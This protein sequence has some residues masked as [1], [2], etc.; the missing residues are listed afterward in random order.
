M[1]TQ[2]KIFSW[3]GVLGVALV[4]AAAVLALRECGVEAGSWEACAVDAPMERAH[5]RSQGGK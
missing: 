4:V 1:T 3:L 5:C 2:D